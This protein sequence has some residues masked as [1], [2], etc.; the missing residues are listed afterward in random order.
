M[1]TVVKD[2]GAVTAYAYA[3]AGGYTGTEAEFEALLGNIAED[4]SEIENLSVTVTT[5]PA[6]S[7]AT[8]SYSNGV[9]SLGIPKGDKGDKGD[10]GATGATG[11]QG[12]PGDV[13]NL[14]SAYSTSSTYGVGDYCIY[15]SQLYR[16]TT[17]IT[18]AE[19]WTAAHWTAAVLGDDIGDLKSAV[20]ELPYAVYNPAGNT[21]GVWLDKDGKIN[22]YTG[23]S[24]TEFLRIGEEATYHIKTG[25]TSPNVKS[26]FYNAD[27]EF[28]S[29]FETYYDGT[30]VLT[31]VPNAKYVRFTVQTA[32]ASDFAYSSL[33]FVDKV[34][35]IG[36]TQLKEASVVKTYADEITTGRRY[37]TDGSDISAANWSRTPLYNVNEGD[38]VRVTNAHGIYAVLFNSSKVATEYKNRNTIGNAEFTVPSGVSFIGFNIVTANLTVYSCTI[39][40]IILG[41]NYMIPW[42]SIPSKNDSAWQNKTYISHGDSITWQDGKAYTQGEHTGEIAIG[43][44]SIFSEAVG[45]KNYNNQGK[46]G[47][48]MA[49]VNGNG[50]V[51]TIM[52]IADYSVYDLCTIA[53]GTNDFK[54]NVPIGTE[55]Q[56]GDTTF[57][58]STFYG[59]YRKAVEYILNSSPTI[60]LVLMT[61]LQRDNAGYDVNYTN[62][63]GA[64]LIDYVNAIKK[65]GD[66]YGLPVC[67]MYGNSGF[68]KK[69][70]A[71]YT[72]DGLHPND[73]GYQRMGDYLTG[74]LNAVGN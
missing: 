34:D 23:W 55:G 6:G 20:D 9:L 16:C 27:K 40:G 41:A 67:D 13:A 44:Q 3:V 2:L 58:D 4:L 45:L 62:S 49:V 63:A 32:E 57:D 25:I 36:P 59:A 38:V 66:M 56:I 71:T 29:A 18:T 5:I 51:N 17:A 35:N 10:T 30:H 14:A 7:S 22:T 42:L 19:A 74:F 12:I 24:I 50:V 26:C 53:C 37:D 47:W 43:Y 61:P 69:T 1:A 48:S 73:V 46:S 52:A 31:P 39:N 70:L 68:T 65:I 28:L 8:A 60:R 15:N 72:M 21:N 64:K 33:L 11:P 54:L